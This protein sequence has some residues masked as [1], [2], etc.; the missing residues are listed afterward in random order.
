MANFVKALIWPA[1]VVGLSPP[2][3]AI[4]LG[5]AF[6]L[7]PRYVKPHIERYLFHDQ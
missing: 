4:A 5:V 7:F 6:L 1:Y 3:G 2:I